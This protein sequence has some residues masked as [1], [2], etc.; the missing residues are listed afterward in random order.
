MEGVKHVQGIIV[1]LL[2]YRRAVGKKLLFVLSAIGSQQAAATES[3]ADAI[4]Q[5]IDYVATYPNNGITYRASDMVLAGHSDAG[6]L[7]ENRA[8]S[9]FGAHIFL[10]EY[11]TMFRHNLPILAIAKIIKFVMSSAT[12]DELAT[13]FITAQKMVPIL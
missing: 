8:R 3:T 7:N 13:M 5:L 4:H 6:Y 10:L 11:E 12:E 1:A 2:W 9:R